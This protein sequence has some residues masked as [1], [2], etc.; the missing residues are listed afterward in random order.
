MLADNNHLCDFTFCV[1]YILYT[2]RRCLANCTPQLKGLNVI[3]RGKNP[4]TT[5]CAGPLCNLQCYKNLDMLCTEFLPMW[6]LPSWWK[7]RWNGHNFTMWTYLNT[8][9]TYPL[10]PGY[11]NKACNQIQVDLWTVAG[12]MLCSWVYNFQPV[13]F[14]GPRGRSGD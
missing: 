6:S 10:P 2:R 1:I 4:L 12:G 8:G 11:V 9:F 14:L 3:E 13:I 7:T 5:W